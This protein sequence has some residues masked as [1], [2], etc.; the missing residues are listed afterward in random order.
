MKSSGVLD[1]A[2]LLGGFGRMKTASCSLMDASSAHPV[3]MAVLKIAIDINSEK[4]LLRC[5]KIFHKK[6]YTSFVESFQYFLLFLNFF[7]E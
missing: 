5:I 4:R 6:I 3:K 2:F 1:D 7:F